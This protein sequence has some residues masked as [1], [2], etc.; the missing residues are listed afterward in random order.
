M[1]EIIKPKSKIKAGL[2]AIFLGFL[3]VHNFYLGHKTKGIIQLL[4][5]GPFFVSG[6]LGLLPGIAFLFVSFVAAITIS[7]TMTEV[8]NP[9]AFVCFWNCRYYVGCI[10]AMIWGWVEAILIFSGKIKTDANG[11]LLK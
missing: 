9:I 6:N 8:F 5:S 10:P 11:V 4:I 2:L 1:E 7:K 3:G